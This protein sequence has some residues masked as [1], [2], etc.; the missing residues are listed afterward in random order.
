[1]LSI[2][3]R[4]SSSRSIS[5]PDGVSRRVSPIV[6]ARRHRGRLTSRCT[7]WCQRAAALLGGVLLSVMCLSATAQTTVIDAPICADATGPL[8]TEPAINVLSMNLAHGRG[9]GLNQ[10]LQRGETARRN[11]ETAAALLERIDAD[12]VALQEADAASAW[13]GRFDH[14]AALGQQAGYGCRLH[15]AHAQSP[16]FAFGTAL[17]SR[18]QFARA[19]IHD[20]RPT[21][22]TLRKGFVAAQ[23]DWN[24]AGILDE[25]RRVT[26]VSVHLD[27]SRRSS[28]VAQFEE[29]R[30]VLEPFPR[31]LV[32]MGD[33]NAEWVDE[34]SPLRAFAEA[35]DLSAWEAGSTAYPTYGDSKRLDWILISS[36]LAFVRHETL[37][38]EISDHRPVWAQ[39]RWQKPAQEDDLA[40]TTQ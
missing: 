14:V 20:F 36:E 32:V 26:F 31:P 22:P 2:P 6:F 40:S 25:P 8:L 29:L 1:M 24:P 33:F 39:L 16:L 21:P 5:L 23:V 27:F 12:V 18:Y 30:E 34:A 28:R 13:S 38:D 7:P 4:V 10:L 19:A 9:T 35:L 15:G 37:E 3:M 11:I 17:L